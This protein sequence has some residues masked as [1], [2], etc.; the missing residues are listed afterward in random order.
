M[1]KRATLPNGLR[2]VTAAMPHTRSA[3]VS[4]YVGAGSRYEL[5]AEAGLS[6]FLE[7]M[8]FKGASRRPTAREISEAI[9]RVGGAHNAATDR[10]LTVYYAKVPDTAAYDAIDI[11]ADM[12]R[13]PV[14]DPA[15][16]EKERL[17]ILEELAMV[18]DNPS[19][20]AG[21]LIDETL[22]PDQPLGR[23]VGGSPESVEA[24]PIEAVTAYLR[25]QYVPSNL[26]LAVA[27]NIA[28]EGVVEAA[29]RWLGEMPDHPAGAWHPAVA[30]DGAARL[31]VKQ[32]PTEQAHICIAYPSVSLTHPD[33]FAVDLL[34]AVL[35]EG[36]SSR[37]FLQLREELALVYDVHSYPSEF[38]DAGAFTIYAG[39]DPTNARVA[40]E[41]IFGEIEGLL[42]D[43]P[44][45]EFEKGK[46]MAK[47]RMLLRMEDTRSVAGWIGAQELLLERVET[48]DEV[49]ERIAA[50]TLDDVRRVGREVFREGEA[51]IA[52]VGPF[53]DDGVF[54][55]LV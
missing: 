23:N 12:V 52:A 37:L 9:E 8:L 3:T 46:Q 54:A 49:T 25:G 21:I 39:C 44:E 32:K 16:L 38:R 1:Y 33:R 6:H 53:E 15:E 4:M 5:D 18:E 41:A 2:I 35:G 42:A 17:V 29:Q 43:L 48:V 10:E 55:G 30:R 47:G 28:H 14:M 20:L 31:A 19:E 27:G 24:L 40:T 7:H 11:L 22:W 36:M 26:V 45:D 34:S 50:V 51:T 13:A